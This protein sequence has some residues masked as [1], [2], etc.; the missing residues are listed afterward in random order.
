M[1]AGVLFFLALY[2]E[3][4]KQKEQQQTNGGNKQWLP[5]CYTDYIDH[6]RASP[7]QHITEFPLSLLFSPCSPSPNQS[8]QYLYSSLSPALPLPVSRT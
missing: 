3:S 5:A 4:F 7:P 1:L 6:S 2:I 8:M